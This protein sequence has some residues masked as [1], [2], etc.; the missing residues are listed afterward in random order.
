MKHGGGS[1]YPEFTVPYSLFEFASS[2]G[3]LISGLRPRFLGRISAFLTW[4]DM[5][6]LAV[7]DL[8]N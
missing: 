5:S 6:H 4:Y 1:S 2:A 7:L 3:S 8:I